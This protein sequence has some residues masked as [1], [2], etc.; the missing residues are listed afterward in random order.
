MK[1]EMSLPTRPG[2]VFLAPGLD[3]LALVLIFPVFVSA[4]AS[5]SGYE[6]K[7]PDS[8]HRIA[9]ME[10]SISVSIKGG[11][12]PQIWVNTQKVS[13]RELVSVVARESEDW[14][15]GGSVGIVLRVDRSVPSGV[16]SRIRERLSFEGY[17]VY[18]AGKPTMK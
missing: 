3:L 18:I 12:E 8:L 14:Q 6:V 17:R 13:E 11:S 7:L 2:L 16:M 4:F 1:L 9:R 5:N 10:H 15:G